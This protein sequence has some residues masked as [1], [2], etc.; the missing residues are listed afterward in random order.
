[1][2]SVNTI[3]PSIDGVGPSCVRLPPGP[4][5]TVMEYLEERFSRVQPSTWAARMKKR[6]VVDEE[7]TPLSPA[8]TFRPGSYVF[9]Y[10]ELEEEAA[11]PFKETVLYQDDHIVVADKPHF[12][13]VMPSGRFLRETL[14]V[15]LKKALSLPDL[16]PLHRID[17]ETAGTVVFS[18][19]SNT[20]GT[21]ASLFQNHQVRKVYEAVAPTS[22]AG[23][24]PLVYRSRLARGK[25]FFR[26]EQVPGPPNSVTHIDI[27]ETKDN[28]AL[29]RLTPLTGRKHQLRVHLAS[30]GIPVLNDRFYPHVLPLAE[31]NFSLPLQ[32]LARSVS[33]C[34]P[35]TGQEKA[36]ASKGELRWSM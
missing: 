29:Y 28:L 4:W 8:S 33:F 30:L 24:F 36:F 3:L 6:Q 10:R 11:I 16:V 23:H 21:Y 19:N 26:M 35:I 34:D 9:Y 22:E 2:N 31:D 20:R 14:L 13:P 27:L 12:L 5:K 18:H 1:M 17:R 15:R 32:L 25:P 7:G